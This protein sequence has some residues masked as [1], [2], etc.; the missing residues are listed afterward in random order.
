ML[1]HGRATLAVVLHDQVGLRQVL[2]TTAFTVGARHFRIFSTARKMLW[3]AAPARTLRADA[4]SS[5]ERPSTWRKTKAVRSTAV[6][7]SSA[8]RMFPC[9]SALYAIRSGLGRSEAT[10]S[11]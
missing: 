5:T 7:D 1:R 4:I 10:R 8:D 9:I 3:R 6:S 11:S 2:H